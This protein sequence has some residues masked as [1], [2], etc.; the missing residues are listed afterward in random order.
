MTFL[1]TEAYARTHDK[2]HTVQR[3]LLQAKDFTDSAFDVI[4][5]HGTFGRAFAHHQT[6]PGRQSAIGAGVHLKPALGTGMA[7]TKNG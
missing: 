3:R 2:V 7:Q 1:A 5:R 4:A 6:Q